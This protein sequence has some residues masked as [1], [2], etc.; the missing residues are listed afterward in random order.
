MGDAAKVQ[1]Q[2]LYGLF[3]ELV[4]KKIIISM[5]VVGADFDRLTCITGLEKDDDDHYLVVDAPDDFEETAKQKQ[6]WHIRF[7]FNG[8]DQLEYIF[9]TRG[10][11]LCPRGLKIPFPEHVERLQRRRNFRVETLAGTQ[12]HFRLKKIKGSFHV[13][14]ISLGGIYGALVKHN[15]KFIRG[16]VLKMDQTIED[17]GMIF[18]G[19]G[20]KP[21]KTIIV[22]KATVRRVEHDP[23]R[24]LYRYAFAFKEMQKHERQALTEVIYDLQRWHLQRRR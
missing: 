2:K 11:E 14:N 8:P 9:S 19:D 4:E 23:E 16:P 7:N 5:S 1:G 21:D 13:F 20:D 10:G 6:Q 22:Q 3:N 24:G 17:V 15:F 12:M 18:P